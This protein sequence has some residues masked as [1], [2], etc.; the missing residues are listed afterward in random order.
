VQRFAGKLLEAP[1][2]WFSWVMSQAK[3]ASFFLLSCGRYGALFLA[4]ICLTRRS[5]QFQLHKVNLDGN[6][7][8]EIGCGPLVEWTATPA[9]IA[10]KT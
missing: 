6:V 7:V 8:D 1:L 9:A 3:Q 4:T 5:I 2:Q 10:K